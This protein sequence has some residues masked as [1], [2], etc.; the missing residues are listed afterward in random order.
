MP[1]RQEAERNEAGSRHGVSSRLADGRKGS[2]R[3]PAN[4]DVFLAGEWREA[5][6]ICRPWGGMQVV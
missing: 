4:G 5:G 6:G 3:R 1:A 2:G